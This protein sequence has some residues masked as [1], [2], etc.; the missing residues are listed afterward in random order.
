MLRRAQ[1]DRMKSK[2]PS[3]KRNMKLLSVVAGEIGGSLSL[4]SGHAH[5]EITKQK[6]CFKKHLFYTK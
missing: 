5:K 4:S 1:E 6:C 3:L 2:E